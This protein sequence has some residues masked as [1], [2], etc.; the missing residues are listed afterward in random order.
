M[1]FRYQGRLVCQN[2]RSFE[3]AF[4]YGNQIFRIDNKN[5]SMASSVHDILACSYAGLSISWLLV[6]FIPSVNYIK[7]GYLSAGFF[8][9]FYGGTLFAQPFVFLDSNE[10]TAGAAVYYL[11]AGVGNFIGS[12]VIPILQANGY[13]NAGIYSGIIFYGVCSVFTIM[14]KKSIPKQVDEIDLMDSTML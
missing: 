12:K 1:T 9:G 3:I 14:V 7:Y 11:L 4:F 2:C 5:S 6:F 8:T 13:V 10:F